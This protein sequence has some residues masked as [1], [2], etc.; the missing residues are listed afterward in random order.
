MKCKDLT[1]IASW[2]AFPDDGGRANEVVVRNTL[3]ETVSSEYNPGQ[4]CRITECW[5]GD[6]CPLLKC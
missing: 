6:N 5:G 3:A 2:N 4:F 1:L